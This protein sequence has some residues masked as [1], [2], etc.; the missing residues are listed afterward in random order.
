MGSDWGP[1]K[2]ICVFTKQH[3]KP[4]LIPADNE[5]NNADEASKSAAD[6]CERLKDDI[7]KNAKSIADI[8]AMLNDKMN[9]IGE[10]V[11]NAAEE[12]KK[13]MEARDVALEKLNEA[14]SKVNVSTHGEGD[15]ETDEQTLDELK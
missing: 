4:H 5:G 15:G 1:W 10:L 14:K 7:V 6:E 8:L 9:N 2:T 12:M 13:A 3:K 11:K